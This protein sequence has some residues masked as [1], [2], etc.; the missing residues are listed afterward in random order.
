MTYQGD[1]TASSPLLEQIATQDCDILLE[2]IR[3]V[4]NAAMQGERQQYMI[5]APYQHVPDRKGHAN[6]FKPKTVK[7]AWERSTSTFRQSEK[8]A[9]IPRHS[10]RDCA[11]NGCSIWRWPSCT[12]SGSLPAK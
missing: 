11:V 5:A 1:L 6:G 8:A 12:S 2:L 4:I 10:K 7:P 9:F 3:I